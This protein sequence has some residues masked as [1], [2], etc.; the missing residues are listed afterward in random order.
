MTYLD[1]EYYQKSLKVLESYT[2]VAGGEEERGQ[3][4]K[5]KKITAHN[6]LPGKKSSQQTS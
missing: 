5:K 4:E 2:I 1:Q 6:K 3:G